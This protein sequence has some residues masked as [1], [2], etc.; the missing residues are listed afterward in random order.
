MSN[1]PT[2]NNREPSLGSIAPRD[3]SDVSAGENASAMAALK[4]T[5]A[6]TQYSPAVPEVETGFMNPGPMIR[7]GAFVIIVFVGGF[8]AWASFAQ[9]ES[10][11]N[12]PGVIVVESHRKTIQ[13]LE[14]GIVKDVLVTEGQTV[15]Q[16]QPLLRL[17]ETQAESNYNL[18]QDQANGL[19]AQEARLIAERDGASRITFPPELLAQRDNPKVAQ[20]IAGEENAFA[21]RT[22][23]L[24]KQLDILNQRNS[25]NKSQIAGLQSQQDAVKQQG[26]LIDQEAT[27]VE[28]LYKQGLS[29]LPR[30]LALRR[31]AADLTGQNGQI[32][33]HMAQIELNSEENNLQAQNLRNQQLTSVATDLRDVETKKFDVLSRLNAAK[34]VMT[35]LDLVAPVAGKIVNLA[36]HTQGAVIKPG[37]T[38]MEI[39]PDDDALELEAHVR[40][41]EA[42]TIQPGMEA[43]ISFNSYKQRRL[44]QLTGK[45]DTISAD[46]LTD[47]RTG[48]PYFNVLVT[49]NSDALK[50]YSA[51]RLIPGLPADVAIAT[52]TRTMMDYFLSPVMDVIQNGMREK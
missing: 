37:D 52:G 36:I 34:D 7:R 35:R 26:T 25:E 28:D 8:I 10:A 49:V 3:P 24:T 32:A 23:A 44:P 39:V 5:G 41:D 14:G 21:T 17:E 46:R 4:G 18:L 40:P 2:G 43:H 11:V 30:V 20:V 1:E 27:G 15:K 47:Q 16:G 48:Q 29:T 9:L 22:A 19:I 13:H 12:A 31:Q 51:V 6:L 42:D 50:D 33:E 45:V 38:V